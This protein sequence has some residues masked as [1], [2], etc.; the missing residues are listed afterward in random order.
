MAAHSAPE[1]S[2]EVRFLFVFD[3]LRRAVFLVG[4]DKAGDWHGWYRSSI[5]LAEA[6]YQDY[7]T[8][9]EEDTR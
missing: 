6:A 8:Q 2:A 3:P 1:R 9:Q 4:G 7:V 5:P